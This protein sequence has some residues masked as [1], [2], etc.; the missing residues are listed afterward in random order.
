MTE[1]PSQHRKSFLFAR[2][3]IRGEIYC[4]CS[5]RKEIALLLGKPTRSFKN[6]W[7]WGARARPAR[8]K[9]REARREMARRDGKKLYREARRKRIPRKSQS[10]AEKRRTRSNKGK[11]WGND[12]QEWIKRESQRG[13]RAYRPQVY[14][15][16]GKNRKITRARGRRRTNES[17]GNYG[18]DKKEMRAENQRGRAS[19]ERGKLNN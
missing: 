7:R 16:R 17:W 2:Q 13:R 8:E 1:G 4:G 6:A 12:I 18:D 15:R 9:H 14:S 3:P 19:A 11:V 10:H 5:I